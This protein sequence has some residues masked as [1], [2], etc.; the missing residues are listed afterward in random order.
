M[1]WKSV[2]VEVCRR[3]LG[4]R[5]WC[6]RHRHIYPLGNI[7]TKQATSNA[8]CTIFQISSTHNTNPTI[9]MRLFLNREWSVTAVLLGLG[10][11]IYYAFA[12]VWPA[13]CAVLYANGDPMYIGFISVLIGMGSCAPSFAHDSLLMSSL[14]F[15]TGQISA[16]LFARTIGRTK[17]QVMVAFTTGGT[18]LGCKLSHFHF[19]VGNPLTWL[20]QVLQP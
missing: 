5:C 15:I 4:Y 3:Y 19:V 7:R 6:G 13:Q 20:V 10:A 16:G 9:S 11:G 2:S 18:L 14:G 1:G 17:Y 12:I 8:V